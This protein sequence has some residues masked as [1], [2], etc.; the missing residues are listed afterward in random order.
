M[1]VGAP[2]P[3]GTDVTAVEHLRAA[4]R[5]HG[6]ESSRVAVALGLE[7]G[8]AHLL[9]EDRAV[10][11]RR[12]PTDEP[13]STL[14]SLF[15]L[16]L[17]VDPVEAAAALAPL[18][19]EAAEHLGLVRRDD[20]GWVHAA[21][22]LMPVG[23][24][25][26]ACDHGADGE[27]QDHV[28]P[29]ARSSMLLSHLTVRRRVDA[30][31]DLGTGSGFQALQAARHAARVVATDPSARALAF[32]RFN[33]LLNEVTGVETRAGAGFD[34]A[35]G[36]C[37]D[38]V[39]ANP[40][41][42]ISPDADLLYRDADVRGDA[43]SRSV[44]EGAAAHLRPDGVAQVLVN[45][46]HDDGAWD[47]PLREWVRDLGCD[48]WLLHFAS[49]DPTSY[50]E[51]WNAHHRDEPTAY[52]ATVDRWVRY[53]E[54]EGAGMIGFGM[55]VLRRDDGSPGRVWALDLPE[56]PAAG[57]SQRL[58]RVVETTARLAGMDDEALLGARLLRVDGLGAE[59]V[60]RF[61]ADGVRQDV[62][63]LRLEDPLPARVEVSGGTIVLV[64]LLDGTRTLQEAIDGSL[65]RRPPGSDPS[66]L[67]DGALAGARTLLELGLLR[68]VSE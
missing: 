43:L 40:P 33:C 35:A 65:A 13:L 60:L 7:R 27:A 34:P 8:Q 22:H 17:G 38:L 11:L 57:A 63:T 23:D 26:V 44:V 62:T 51:R 41:F 18:S 9:G 53:L 50:A 55:V 14:V 42:V 61:T 54:D 10:L 19:L 39:I 46:I 58:W 37:F 2:P 29:P 12:L 5:A 66:A 49:A 48:A 64:S 36:A 67:A 45:W 47:T 3:D 68:F 15:L 30:V 31:F 21:V 59:Q 25:V 24:L 1:A 20:E 16:T 4:L 32:T 6:Y 52:I 28:M 56:S